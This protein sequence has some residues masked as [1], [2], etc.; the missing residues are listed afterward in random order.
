MMKVTVIG[1]WGGFPGKG[2]ATSGYLVE[3]DGFKLLIDCG[4][5]V[6][7]QLQYYMN[8]EDLDAVIL[9]HYHN[10]HIC[11]IGAL[12]YARLIKGFLGHKTHVLPI[13]AHAENEV[14]FNKLTYKD[15]SR[16]LVFNPETEIHIGPFTIAFI[17]TRHPITCYAMKIKTSTATIVYTADTSYFDELISFS[18]NA[19][20][21][22]CECNLYEGMDGKMA[23]HMT[24]TD[25]GILA[26]KSEV[27]QLVLTH[28]PHFGEH[29]QLLQQAKKK[30]FGPIN[31][32]KSGWEWIK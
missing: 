19:D 12:Q 6:V 17:K 15:V 11:D 9:S 5:G 8:L 32:A 20:L 27:Q 18:K 13:Y 31:L 1:Y 29:N 26:Q 10:D 23:G 4:S 16:G 30:Y 7:A 25:A 28:L 3:S 22:L 24:S 14:E 21:L 2:E